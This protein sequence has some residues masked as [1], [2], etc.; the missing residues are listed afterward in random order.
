M[1]V[2]FHGW[3]APLFSAGSKADCHGGG[4]GR[5]NCSAHSKQEGRGVDI[6][7]GWDWGIERERG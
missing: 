2:S 3:L 1:E 7:V 4:G 5:G 6:G